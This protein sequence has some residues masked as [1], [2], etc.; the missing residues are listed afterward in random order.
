MGNKF[1]AEAWGDLNGDATV[2]APS[3]RLT[4]P[5]VF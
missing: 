2:S 3:G 1:V 5:L 4:K